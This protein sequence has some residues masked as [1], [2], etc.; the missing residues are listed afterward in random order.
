MHI[1]TFFQ[2]FG[3]NPQIDDFIIYRTEF[4]NS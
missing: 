3:E 4:K 1:P 2:N